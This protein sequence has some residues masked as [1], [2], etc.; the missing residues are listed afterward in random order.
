MPYISG[1]VQAPV[2]ER[3]DL[4]HLHLEIFSARRSPTKLKFLAGSES[5]AGVFVNDILPE[6]A[7]QR[8]RDAGA[9]DGSGGLG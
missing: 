6:D 2:R 5:A 4:S 8:L 9:T 3:R 7:A 1:W